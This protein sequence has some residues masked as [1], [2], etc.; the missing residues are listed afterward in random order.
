MT[1]EPKD[2]RIPPSEIAEGEEQ[3]EVERS[4]SE[5]AP[6]EQRAQREPEEDLE[7]EGWYQPESSAQK[8][9]PRDEEE[10]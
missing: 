9:A 8:G 4:A 1:N 2:P 6:R 5:R 3:D 7:K 10:G